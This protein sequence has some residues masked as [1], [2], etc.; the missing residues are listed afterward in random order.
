MSMYRAIEG[1]HASQ[2]CGMPFLLRKAAQE[3]N[4]VCQFG[5]LAFTALV[6][7]VMNNEM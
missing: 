2:V 7:Y 4:E 6:N 3:K 5:A 1:F